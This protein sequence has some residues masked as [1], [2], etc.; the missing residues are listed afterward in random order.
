MTDSQYFCDPEI[1]MKLIF[2]A[3]NYVHDLLLNVKQIH[4]KKIYKKNKH[5][6]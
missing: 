2:S 3:N 4:E 6:L 5:L 1:Q